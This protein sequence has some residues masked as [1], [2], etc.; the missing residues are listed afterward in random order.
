MSVPSGKTHPATPV[1]E[2]EATKRE[3]LKMATGGTKTITTTCTSTSFFGEKC[4]LAQSHSKRHSWDTNDYRRKKKETI[5][6]AEVK[7]TVADPPKRSKVD[8]SP[9]V[10]PATATATSEIIDILISF[11]TTGS[12]YPCLTQVRREVDNLVRQLFKDIPDLRI[13]IIAHGDY[14]DAP[15]TI[16]KLGLTKDE[17]AISKFVKTVDSTYGGDAP[18]CYELVLH[19]ART[20][21]WKSGR[22][23]V[24]VLI[25]DDVPHGP[26]YAQ[27]TKKIDWRNELGLL[28]EAG[29]HVYA[30]QALGRR[31]ATN[32]YQEVAKRTGGFHLELNQFSHIRDLILAICYKQQG[33]EALQNFERSVEHSGRMNR[34]LDKVFSTLL[35]R[36]ISSSF[37]GQRGDGLVPVHAARFQVLDVDKNTDIKSFVEANG[38]T[39][40]KGRGFYEFTKSVEIQDHKE[41]I[42]QERATGDMFSGR[43]AREILGLPGY[44]T[45]TVSPQSVPQLRDG[46]YTA[47]VQ[48]TSNN[49][50][51]LAG[52]KFLYEMD[53][54]DR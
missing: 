50:K 30:V 18:E 14:C 27:N 24:L 29:V 21:D 45:V 5:G 35:G 1:N 9:V 49:R 20:F 41:V 40:K 51:L 37:S 3:E 26:T 52:T 4:K 39:F 48:S 32:F 6:A 34:S 38:A 25:G 44:G 33:D 11:D 23:K 17:A 31:H 12:M 22:N 46:T 53:D 36:E 8:K 54:W 13:G 43:E 2:R 28:L 47:F 15:R 7:A 10:A 19:E 42:L 16:T